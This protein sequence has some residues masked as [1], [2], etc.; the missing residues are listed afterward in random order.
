MDY[1]RSSILC[2][3]AERDVRK[4]VSGGKLDNTKYCRMTQ[5]PRWEHIRMEKQIAMSVAWIPQGNGVVQMAWNHLMVIQCERIRNS[6]DQV[7]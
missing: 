3:T 7:R 4:A 6:W 5:H 1:Q 2:A